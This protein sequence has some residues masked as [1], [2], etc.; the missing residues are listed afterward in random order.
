MGCMIIELFDRFVEDA[1]RL[2]IDLTSFNFTICNWAA[3]SLWDK[4]NTAAWCF[5]NLKGR[6]SKAGLPV[7]SNKKKIMASIMKV[8]VRIANLV[9][10]G[11]E[12]VDA[13]DCLGVEYSPGADAEFLAMKKRTNKMVRKACRNR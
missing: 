9:A 11:C 5:T 6:L 7:A 13:H 12:A 10:D 2:P 3:R 4:V 1:E 8:A